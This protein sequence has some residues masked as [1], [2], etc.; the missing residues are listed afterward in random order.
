MIDENKVPKRTERES[1]MIEAVLEHGFEIINDD[2][3][4]FK[5]TEDNI[6]SLLKCVNF[7]PV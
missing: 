5:C 1:F 7:K 6:I 4:E 2:A 3:T